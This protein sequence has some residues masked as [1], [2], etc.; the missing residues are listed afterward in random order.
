[1]TTLEIV[2]IFN[3]VTANQNVR[4]LRSRRFRIQSTSVPV[5]NPPSPKSIPVIELL[6]LLTLQ[7]GGIRGPKCA[8]I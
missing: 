4:F 7:R 2:Q 6:P 1:M 3:D 5:V 8:I